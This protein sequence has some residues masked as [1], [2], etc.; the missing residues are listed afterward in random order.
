MLNVA[1]R[2]ATPAKTTRN[3]VNRSRNSSLMSLDVLVGELRPRDRLGRRRAARGCDA[4]RRAASCDTPDCAVDRDA[5][6]LVGAVEEVL[7][8]RP[9]SVKAVNVTPPEPVGGAERGD[10]DDR[11]GD[12]LAASGRWSCRPRAGCRCSAAP[13]LIT[14]SS[15]A[16]G[17]RP[18]TMRYGLRAGSSIQLPA[19]VG[20]P[21]PPSASPFLPRSWPKPS[22]RARRRRRRRRCAPCRRATC[23]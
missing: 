6:H 21:L 4:V 17:A 7:A 1:T 13:R 23:R 10:A 3:V 11:D 20:G 5:R 12:R 2:S 15:P 9:S 18:S 8:A 19:S 16:R 14:T 22:T